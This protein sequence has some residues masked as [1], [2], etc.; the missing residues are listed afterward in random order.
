M[1]H[2]SRPKIGFDE[3]QAVISVLKSG[4]L[5]QGARVE[6]FEIEFAKYIGTKYAVG[7]SSGTSALHGAYIACDIKEGDEVITT[8]FTFAS[9]INM[10]K[11]VGAIPVFVDI[12]DDFNI[13]EEQIEA[14]ITDKTKAIVPVHLF[15]KSCSMKPILALAKR[16]NLK[17]IEDCAQACGAEHDFKKVGNFGDCGTFSFYPTKIITTGEGGMVTTNS[18]KIYDVLRLFR[19]HGMTGSEYDYRIV[20]YNYR[21]TDMEAAIGLVQLYKIENFI[22]VRKDIASSYDFYLEDIL[23]T[24]KQ[25]IRGRHVFNNYS[26]CVKNRDM[27]IKNLR[28][29]G[30]DARVYYPESLADLPNANKIAKSI[31]SIPIRP[32][33][34]TE[35]VTHIVENIRTVIKNE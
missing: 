14:H 25:E 20:G 24:P 21:M 32:N 5:A 1:I 29:N 9:T 35:E 27:F 4:M 13:D 22:R 3:T 31:V 10:I 15:G 26:S 8:P 17:V 7:Y 33:M 30:I 28:A 16:Y 11:A 6:E 2:I 18:K 23:I 12:K 34:T 19:N